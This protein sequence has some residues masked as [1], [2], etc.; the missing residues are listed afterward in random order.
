MPARTRHPGITHE[1]PSSAATTLPP[2]QHLIG[3]FLR[4]GTHMGRPAPTVP[5]DPAITIGGPAVPSSFDLPVAALAGLPRRELT[6]DFHCVAGWSASAVRWEG[7]AFETFFRTIVEPE[8][9]PGTKVTHLVFA[10]LDG[11]RS[12]LVAE[13]ALDDHVLLAER[14]AGRPLG[15][16][17]G[18]P[19]RLVSPLQYGYVSTKHLCRIE[20]HAGA[21]PWRRGPLVTTRLLEPHPRARV[22]EE[23]RHGSLPGWLVRPIYRALEAPLLRLGTG[24]EEAGS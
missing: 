7:V 22:W 20:V 5:P 8:L 6:A 18:A 16:E 11:Y 15:A 2:G 4:F 19:L 21:P 10:G 13:D 3:R 23:E 9:E 12:V 17:H 24:N 1:E 14:L